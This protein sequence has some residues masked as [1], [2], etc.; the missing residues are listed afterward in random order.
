MLRSEQHNHFN[1]IRMIAAALVLVSHSFALSSGDPLLEPLRKNL[2]VTWGSIAVD[3][4]FVTSGFLVTGSM[5]QRANLRDFLLSRALRIY[6]GLLVALVVTVAICSIWF[7]SRSFAEF[8]FDSATWRYLILN[9][10]LIHPFGIQYFIPGVLEGVPYAKNGI[11]P[12]NGSLWTLPVEVRMYLCLAIGYLLLRKFTCPA[13]AERIQLKAKALLT[14]VAIVLVIID[15]AYTVTGGLRLVP[16]MAAM[17]FVGGAMWCYHI[18]FARLLPLGC[19]LLLIVL[20]SI[21]LGKTAFIVC[22]TLALPTI[23]LVIAFLPL[24]SLLI[25]NRLGD[26]SYGMYIYAF[27]VQQWLASIWVGIDAWTMTLMAVLMTLAFAAISWHV[28]EK[29]A[30]AMKPV[31]HEPKAIPK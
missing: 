7:T 31:R 3:V 11:G 29:R 1:L 24:K 5:I 23:V 13:N 25:Y 4:F 21:L 27:P 22:Y 30:L 28:V 9:A 19:L 12:I 8:W 18:N 6:P 20:L 16:H 17:F 2:G 26:Y 14:A 15:L 10:V